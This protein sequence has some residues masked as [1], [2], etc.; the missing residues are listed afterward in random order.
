MGLGISSSNKYVAAIEEFGNL[1]LFDYTKETPE[2]V[3][4]IKLGDGYAFSTAFSPDSRSIAVG[5]SNGKLFIV[6]AISGE[7]RKEVNAHGQ[8]VLSVAYSKDGK[9]IAT[10]ANDRLI[11]V[12][13][14]AGELLHL[15]KGHTG[16]I[17]SLQFSDDSHVLYSSSGDGTVKKWDIEK[18]DVL[19]T[20]QVSDKVVHDFCLSPNEHQM[21]TV[22]KDR[23]MLVWDLNNQTANYPFE[24]EN[25]EGKTVD[26]SPT[27]TKVAVG[28]E[29]GRLMLFDVEN[30]MG[31]QVQENK[32]LVEIYPSPVISTSRFAYQFEVSEPVSLSIY[33]IEGKMEWSTQSLPV[34]GTLALPANL[35]TGKYLYL[36][37][38]EETVIYR[39]KFLKMN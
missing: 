6:D 11:K 12:W 17:T 24:F 27:E 13:D 8:W 23:K 20:L 38:Q 28:T 19:Y 14:A 36:W 32:G 5:A 22:S 33:S 37:K 30:A 7:T 9:L 16:N 10:G 15:L 39:G 4:T 29:T 34:A 31:I 3:N 25:D 35:P 2:L 26:W 1:M 21:V 18:E